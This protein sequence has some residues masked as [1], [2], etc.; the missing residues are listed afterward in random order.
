MSDFIRLKDANI[1]EINSTI[2]VIAM[3]KSIVEKKT[4]KDDLYLDVTLV[5]NRRNLNCKYFGVDSKK[6][7]IAV[8]DVIEAT[9]L[10]NEYNNQPSYLIKESKVTFYSPSDYIAWFEKLPQ[11]KV[12]FDKLKAMV[13]EPIYQTVL[14]KLVSKVEEEFSSVPAAKSMHHTEFGGCLAHSTLVAM[15]CLRIGQLY[16]SVYS[17]E[18]PFI[19]LELL[20]TSALIH[21]MAKVVELEWNALEGNCGYSSDMSCLDS[22]ITKLDEWLTVIAVECGILEEEKYRLLR[23]CILAHHGKLEWGSPVAPAIPEALVLSVC[24]KLDADIWG[25]NNACLDLESGSSD[26]CKVCGE[27]KRVYKKI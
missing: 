16:N 7:N 24:D 11:L 1:S 14:N 21:D 19:D 5:D 10:V 25:Y 4:A 22:H 17:T 13:N 9:I 8:G 20:V 15:N 23:H 12:E 3:V 27:F 18:K 2:R 6:V 26:Y